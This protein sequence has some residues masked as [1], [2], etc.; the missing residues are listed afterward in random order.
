[1]I[2]PRE[3]MGVI[4]AAGRGTRMLP[5]SERWPKPCLPIAG[6]P[7]LRYQLEALRDLGVREVVV[8]IGHLGYEVVRSLGEGGDLGLRIRYVEQGDALGIAHAVSKLESRIARPFFLFLGDIFFETENLGRMREVFDGSR[9]SGVLA[10]KREPDLEKIKRNFVVVVGKDGLV[11]RVIEKPRH[12][13]TDVKGCGLYLFDL[14]FFDAIRRTPRTA[15]RDEYEITDSIQIFIDDGYGVAAEEVV[16]EDLNLSYPHDLL[17]INLHVLD[18]LGLPSLLGKGV[19][20]AEGTRVERS[21]LMDGVV[22]EAPIQI[23]D[24]LVF[25]DQ[26]LSRDSDLERTILLPGHEIDC[27]GSIPARDGK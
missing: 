2:D 13:R 4:L 9:V 5:F 15:M 3:L 17:A 11:A 19:R 23:R 18:R 14:S 25:P 6:K 8:V 12:P 24:S 10:V 7:L 21:V 20:L 26:V 22:V 27:R 1:M 16:K